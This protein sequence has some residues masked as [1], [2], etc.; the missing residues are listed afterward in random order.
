MS[1]GLIRIHEVQQ[2]KRLP[3]LLLLPLLLTTLTAQR[4]KMYPA[5]KGATLKQS[6]LCFLEYLCNIV[7]SDKIESKSLVGIIP[8]I[9]HPI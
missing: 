7:L 1:F 4:R 5:E 8:R 9:G 6:N 2:I 3:S